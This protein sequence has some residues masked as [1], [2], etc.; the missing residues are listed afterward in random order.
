M[1][2]S[3]SKFYVYISFLCNYILKNLRLTILYSITCTVSCVGAAGIPSG[4]YMMLI[5]VL[6]SIGVP[7]EDVTLIIAVDWFM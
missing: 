6:N 7:I 3:G 1:K 4:G 5:M 2:S